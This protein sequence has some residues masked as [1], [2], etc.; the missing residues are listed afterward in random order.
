MKIAKISKPMYDSGTFVFI[1]QVE[2]RCYAITEHAY[3]WQNIE[4]Q[5]ETQE[6]IDSVKYEIRLIEGE[7]EYLINQDINLG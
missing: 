6:L 4:N 7:V 2:D 1:V 3:Q 5:F